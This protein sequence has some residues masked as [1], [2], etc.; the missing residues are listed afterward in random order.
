MEAKKN[1]EKSSWLTNCKALVEMLS[2]ILC[3]ETKGW[4]T[5]DKNYK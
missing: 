1:P 3:G 5:T 4:K 2:G